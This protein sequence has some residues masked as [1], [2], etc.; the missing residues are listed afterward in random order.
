M[1]EGLQWGEAHLK[2]RES[3]SRLPE[4]RQR[5]RG[6]LWQ[7]YQQAW[8]R[9]RGVRRQELRSG[10]CQRAERGED[11]AIETHQRRRR[12]AQTQQ[13]RQTGSKVQQQPG[14][15]WLLRV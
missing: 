5:G 7:H 13:G 15:T 2:W 12:R 4:R 8:V 1:G 6:R 11:E 10:V 9:T 3:K 14:P